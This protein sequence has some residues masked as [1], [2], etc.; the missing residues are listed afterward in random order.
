ML[1]PV[2]DDKILYGF[3]GVCFFVFCLFILLMTGNVK[4]FL[5]CL[6]A[7]PCSA[8]IYAWAHNYLENKYTDDSLTLLLFTGMTKIGMIAAVPAFAVLLAI[9][10]LSFFLF[11]F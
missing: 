8:V 10:F 4:F 11:K 7:I 3:L 2:N 6:V 5:T 9:F 1:K